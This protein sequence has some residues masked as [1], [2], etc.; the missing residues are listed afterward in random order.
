M[1]RQV[2]VKRGYHRGTK[3]IE[4]GQ[5]PVLLKLSG[6]VPILFQQR[7]PFCKVFITTE[8]NQHEQCRTMHQKEQCRY[9]R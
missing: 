6:C 3:A 2:R 1:N 8:S 7:E 9:P 5:C 4:D